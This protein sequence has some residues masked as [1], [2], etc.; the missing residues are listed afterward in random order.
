MIAKGTSSG[1]GPID[2]CRVPDKIMRAQKSKTG[3]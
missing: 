1:Q 2:G 3:A